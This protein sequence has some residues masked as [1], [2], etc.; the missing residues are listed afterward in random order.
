M[1]VAARA[2]RPSPRTA[3]HYTQSGER[4][5]RPQGECM[6]RKCRVFADKRR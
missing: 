6:K 4:E 5:A 3:K 1:G 2:V